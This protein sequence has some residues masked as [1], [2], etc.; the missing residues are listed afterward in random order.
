MQ[1]K[2]AF[3]IFL[4]CFIETKSE[5]NGDNDNIGIVHALKSYEHDDAADDDGSRNK[6][7]IYKVAAAAGRMSKEP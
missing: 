1:H 3:Y 5:P 7:T 6:F 4:L 2:N